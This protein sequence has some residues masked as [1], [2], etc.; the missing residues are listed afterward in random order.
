MLKKKPMLGPVMCSWAWAARPIQESLTPP[1]AWEEMEAESQGS[2]VNRRAEPAETSWRADHAELR[3]QAKHR[4]WTSSGPFVFLTLFASAIN[5]S[6]AIGARPGQ[7]ASS[8]KSQ[9]IRPRTLG[10]HPPS[11][12][13]TPSITH[14]SSPHT[15]GPHSAEPCCWTRRSAFRVPHWA[16]Y[17]ML[18]PGNISAVIPL[19]FHRAPSLD[20]ILS[21]SV[22]PKA[23]APAI[24]KK[25]EYRAHCGDDE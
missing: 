16:K 25:P 19:T 6:G 4:C 7:L 11:P 12:S 5:S 21:A 8:V 22:R 14:L 17:L 15:K 1:G 24:K 13:T 23:A 3:R 18:L 2:P 9:Q 10:L 20:A